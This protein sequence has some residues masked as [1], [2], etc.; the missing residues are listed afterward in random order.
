MY[1][2]H[3][4]YVFF[5]DL[6][7]I[8]YHLGLGIS[9]ITNQSMS[10]TESIKNC[11]V[12]KAGINC[13]VR[14]I[15]L[16]TYYLI[17]YFFDLNNLFKRRKGG[18]CKKPISVFFFFFKRLFWYTISSLKAQLSQS[19]LIWFYVVINTTYLQTYPQNTIPVITQITGIFNCNYN[20]R[21]KRTDRQKEVDFSS[22]AVFQSPTVS[23]S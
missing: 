11:Q 8:L 21:Y 13:L 4:D 6:L 9:F 20:V 12:P 23:H 15:I 5:Y 22:F 14:L 17:K 18:F 19:C 16:F 10:V 1:I 2:L 3:I 7:L